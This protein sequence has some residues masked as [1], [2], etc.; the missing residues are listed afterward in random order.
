[1]GRFDEAREIVQRLRATTPLV[2]PSTTYLPNPEHRDF[3]YRVRL[4]A[5]EAEWPRPAVSPQSSLRT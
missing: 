4:A 2:V 1:M 5:G 3:F